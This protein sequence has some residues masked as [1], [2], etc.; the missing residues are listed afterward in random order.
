MLVLVPFSLV[1]SPMWPAGQLVT[2]NV[3]VVLA[4]LIVCVVPFGSAPPAR[5]PVP[6]AQPRASIRAMSSANLTSESSMGA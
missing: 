6:S 3:L 5:S 1:L 4:L 2:D